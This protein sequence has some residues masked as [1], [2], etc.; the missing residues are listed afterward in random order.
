MVTVV[1]EAPNVKV[2]AR[3][4]SGLTELAHTGC[5][6]YEP[7]L[8]VIG[9]LQLHHRFGHVGEALWGRIEPFYP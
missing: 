3:G 7:K 1:E 6:A 8:P 9:W 4:G 2:N 5:L